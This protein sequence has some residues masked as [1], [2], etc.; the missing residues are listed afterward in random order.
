MTMTARAI[1]L[2]SSCNYPANHLKSNHTTS[3]LW[4]RG[5]TH[6]HTTHTHTCTHTHTHTLTHTHTHARTHAHTHTHACTHT[7]T[8]THTHTLWRNK[9]DYKKPGMRRPAWFNNHHY[10]IHQLYSCIGICM[11]VSCQKC[12][13]TFSNI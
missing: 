10:L 6:T 8:H 12:T 2:K 4:P 11:H 7:H 13:I 5:C 1:K 3:Y 9:S